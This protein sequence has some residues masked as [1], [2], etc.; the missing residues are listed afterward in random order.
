MK[1]SFGTYEGS[2]CWRIDARWLSVDADWNTR[3]PFGTSFGFNIG[4][5]RPIGGGLTQ[6]ANGFLLDL[7]A[8][9]GE[10]NRLY[11][12][13]G[14]WHVTVGLLTWHTFKATGRDG[15]VIEGDY[16][17]CWPH[18]A[19]IGRY[20]YHQNDDGNWSRDPLPKPGHFGWLTI[21]RGEAA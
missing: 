14:R 15:N 12:R 19:G 5:R 21:T 16:V 20:G 17:R 6:P 18:L 3:F 13:I 10:P 1:V 8:P 9:I 4:P 7:N 11:V 2:P